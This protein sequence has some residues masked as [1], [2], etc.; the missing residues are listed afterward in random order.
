M[1]SRAAFLSPIKQQTFR[2]EIERSRILTRRIIEHLF[3]VSEAS[4]IRIRL[5]VVVQS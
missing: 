5:P 1:R 4:A 2:P 3:V